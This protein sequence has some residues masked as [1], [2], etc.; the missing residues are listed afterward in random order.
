MSGLI[1]NLDLN[2][3]QPQ[4]KASQPNQKHKRF[5]KKRRFLERKGFLKQKQ[6]PQ[7]SQ[8]Y[9]PTKPENAFAGFHGGSNSWK[10]NKNMTDPVHNTD[11]RRPEMKTNSF[12]SSTLSHHTYQP[13]PSLTSNSSN[14]SEEQIHPFHSQLTRSAP[15]GSKT[16]QLKQSSLFSVSY[17]IV[18]DRSQPLADTPKVSLLGEYESGFSTDCPHKTVAIDC[19]MVGTG[20]GARHSELARCSIVSHQGDVVY[21][22]YIKPTNPITNFRT[23][24]SGIRKHHMK[25]ATPFMM[26][27]REILKILAGKVVVGHAIHNDFKALCYFHP[28]SLTRDTSQIPLLN[29][30][31]GFPENVPVSLKR[32][33]KQLLNRDIQAGQKG[34][35]SVED[36][37]ATME[38]YRLVEAEWEREL[39]LAPTED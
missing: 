31:A 22:K 35:S 38:L 19:E 17:S 32:L 28:K 27:Q 36:A 25:D 24:W 37:K 34:H 1:L 3:S 16:E 12:D 39:A 29:R 13:K 11:K 6:L 18:K 20:P 7:Q 26:A 15:R 8:R 30:K 9:Q 23:R 2:G 5:L 4:W 33:T 14:C 21:D 10:R